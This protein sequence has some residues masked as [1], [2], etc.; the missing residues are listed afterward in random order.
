LWDESDGFFGGGTSG[1][2]R[3]KIFLPNRSIDECIYGA[4][5]ISEIDTFETKSNYK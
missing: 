2:E 4:I 1:M 5:F 3:D